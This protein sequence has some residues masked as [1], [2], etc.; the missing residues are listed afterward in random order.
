MP[1]RFPALLVLMDDAARSAEHP[2]HAGHDACVLDARMAMLW[3]SRVERWERPRQAA[4]AFERRF[5]GRR[6][7]P[8]RMDASAHGTH[9]RLMPSVFGSLLISRDV[10][11]DDMGQR[12]LLDTDRRQHGTASPVRY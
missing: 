1:R 5:H 7:M 12:L 4:R 10:P 2:A 9:P 8:Q 3:A 6:T 11:G